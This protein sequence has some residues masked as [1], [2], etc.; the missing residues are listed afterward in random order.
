ME[1]GRRGREDTEVGL[2]GVEDVVALVL[3]V[4]DT[5]TAGHDLAG[6][7]HI[8]HQVRWVHLTPAFFRYSDF[9]NNNNN[10]I[11]DDLHDAVPSSR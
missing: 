8:R 6:H 9:R 4:D 1:R 3:A 11:N 10:N 5:L 7:A 2:P